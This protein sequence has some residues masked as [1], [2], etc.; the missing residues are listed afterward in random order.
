VNVFLTGATGFIGGHTLRALVEQGHLV[1]CLMRRSPSTGRKQRIA[2]SA[3]LASL[4]NVQVVEGEWTSP[5]SWMHHVEGHDV[6][7]NAVG[8]IRERRAATFHAVHT[9]APVA[10]FDAAV[11]AGVR[12]I[13]QISAMGADD[14][15][16]SRYHMSKRAADRH[17]AKRGV[18]YVMLRPSFVYGPGN[19][20]MTF[21]ARLAAL[22]VIPVPGDGQYRVQ[23]LHVT[24]L[25]RAITI[26]MEDPDLADVIVDVGGGQ[27][28][29]FDALLDVLA[30][31]QGRQRG[32]RK[33]HIPWPVM[34]VVAAMTDVMGGHGPITRE[35]LGMLR[36]GSFADNGPFIDQFGF[37]PVPFETGIM[38][39][40]AI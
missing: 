1:T 30:R 6:V 5:E 3:R 36:R 18:P 28:L 40:T 24:D 16:V 9:A 8:I 27:I 7:V 29:S 19:H 25:V 22:P 15:A 37:E 33:V 20:S 35:E 17:L 13:I 31:R 32:A 4:P 11:R 14:K 23:P 26:A 38:Q 39:K 2:A 21:F 34:R 12:K 10:L